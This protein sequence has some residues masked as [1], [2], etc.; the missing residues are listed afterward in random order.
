MGSVRQPAF[1][2]TKDVAAGVLGRGGRGCVMRKGQV[3]S[4]A[5]LQASPSRK[6]FRLCLVSP[7]VPTRALGRHEAQVQ[8]RASTRTLGQSACG[9]GTGP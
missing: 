1:P 9:A 7:L 2:V 8:R 6:G 3:V 5:T 4:M